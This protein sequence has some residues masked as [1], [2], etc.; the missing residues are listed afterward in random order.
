MTTE[1]TRPGRSTSPTT[2]GL[3][4]GAAHTPARMADEVGLDGLFNVCG[5]CGAECDGTDAY[6]VAD[7]W[8][9]CDAETVARGNAGMQ[10]MQDDAD[11][12][13]ERRWDY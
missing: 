2:C 11:W 4:G 6:G 1:N 9:W 3:C 13:E 10:A 5:D 12:A 7:R 8:Y